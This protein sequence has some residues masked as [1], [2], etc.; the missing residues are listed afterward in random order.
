MH[1][2]LEA[3][4]LSILTSPKVNGILTSGG[5]S[6][7]EACAAN[8]RIFV[9]SGSRN[10][11]EGGEDVQV[12]PVQLILALPTPTNSANSM[13]YWASK[14]QSHFRLKLFETSCTS[15]SQSI[16]NTPGSLPQQQC[17]PLI[18]SYTKIHVYF[19]SRAKQKQKSSKRQS[20][21]CSTSQVLQGTRNSLDPIAE[22]SQMLKSVKWTKLPWNSTVLDNWSLLPPSSTLPGLFLLPTVLL[23]P[24]HSATSEVT[25]VKWQTNTV[26]N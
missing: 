4:T 7:C 21:L 9:T 17:R 25:D 8:R 6:W 11:K 19:H 2:T 1:L 23:L 14:P 24:T 3:C 20:E 5:T 13:K 12:Q 10:K 18:A 15:L 26:I 22:V 16:R